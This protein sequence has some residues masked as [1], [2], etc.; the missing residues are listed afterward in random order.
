MSRII[1]YLSQYNDMIAERNA[2]AEQVRELRE[3]LE[4][5]VRFLRKVEAPGF[6]I[7]DAASMS[8]GAKRL[9]ME[10]EHQLGP[11]QPGKE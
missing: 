2:L 8:A 1:M 3:A 10:V 9:R 11:A 7:F 4:T 6:D 5:C